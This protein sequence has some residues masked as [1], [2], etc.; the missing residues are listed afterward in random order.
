MTITIAYTEQDFR[1]AILHYIGRNYLKRLLLPSI[2]AVV[3]VFVAFQFGPD[4]L[5]AVT[6]ML[7]FVIPAML[8]L[9]YWLRIRESLRRFRHLD[10]GRLT[11]TLSE[12]GVVAESASGK[13]ET[14]WKI[15]GELWEFSTEHL[16]F[17]S[18]EQF[19]TLP[20]DRVPPDFI[21]FVRAHIG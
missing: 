21:A 19:I 3:L 15:Y 14:P 18:G 7:V 1:C 16:L 10:H 2:V 8:V 11:L 17:Y 4:W 20:K 12:S 13:S 9:G 5:N 6:V